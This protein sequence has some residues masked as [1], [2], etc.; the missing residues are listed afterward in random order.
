MIYKISRTKADITRSPINFR[1]NISNKGKLPDYRKAIVKKPWGYEYLV[2]QNN[3]VAIGLLHIV[4][5]RKTS[6]HCHPR[7]KTGLILLSGEGLFKHIDETIELGQLD[8]INIKPGAFHS[9]EAF[10]SLP[11][12]PI[13][14]NGIL[15]MEI[16]SPPIKN[17]LC[18]ID[19]VYGRAGTSY[20]GKQN[21]VFQPKATLKFSMPSDDTI[22]TYNFHNLI[23]SVGKASSLIKNETASQP[24]LACVIDRPASNKSKNPYLTLGEIFDYNQLKKHI[25]NENIEDVMLLTVRKEEKQL[26]LTD[27]I[28]NY[29]ADLGIKHIFAVCGGGA[30]H[31]VDSFGINKN[32]KYIATHHEQAAAM[33][34]EGY[35]RISG[36]PG[37]TLVT[38]GP[39]GT[40]AITGVYGS[41]IDSIPHIVIS[42]QVT[43]DTLIKDTGLRQFGI[44]EGNIIEIVKPITKYAVT[45]TDPNTIRYH[46]EKACHLAITGR[47]GPVWLDIP[48]DVQSKTINPEAQKGYTP[49]V[50]NIKQSERAIS[51]GVSKCIELLAKAKR[52]VLI[53]G[54]GIHLSKTERQLLQLVEALKIPVISSWT[55]S[56]II[57]T[58]NPYYIGRSGILGD[59]AGNFTTQNADLII[60]LGSR[61][62]IPQVGYNYNIFARGA[63]KIMVDIDSAE[64][65]KPSLKA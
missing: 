40:N 54:Y 56:D 24:Q 50:I 35:A 37:A 14:E 47:P 3:Y 63:K 45:V 44:Q 19:D 36:T 61:M 29:I 30:M 34:A 43:Q 6:M 55:A 22:N 52:P 17:D 27:Y 49:P 39:G 46:L 41:F 16:E 5:K 12:C 23:F 25:A 59:R 62:S 11:I 38:S 33:A 53:Y 8:S 2:F 32:I 28:A 57:P 26:K 65:N 60:I 51:R 10:S 64:L 4:R 20:E 21:M 31:L 18:R 1:E 58:S 42:G 48:L 9:T 7:K 13:S 15:I